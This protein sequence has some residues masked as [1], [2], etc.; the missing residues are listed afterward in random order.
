M[1]TFP[2]PDHPFQTRMYQ[3]P[4]PDARSDDRHPNLI[5][6]QSHRHHIPISPKSHPNLTD[7]T[8]KSHRHHIPILPT[9]KSH[10]HRIQISPTSHPNLTDI[11]SQSYRHPNL[12]DIASKSH[13]RD[14]INH[15]SRELEKIRRVVSNQQGNIFHLALL[16]SLHTPQIDR[17]S[18]DRG[19]A[20]IIRSRHSYFSPPP[21]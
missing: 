7:I 12:T 9:S 6:S 5:T 17:S 18:H 2:D 8:S 10:R 11:T 13:R 20:G 21:S 15:T 1:H 16:A 19:C 4:D 3:V 14:N